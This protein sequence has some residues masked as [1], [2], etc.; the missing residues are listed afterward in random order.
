MRIPTDNF[1]SPAAVTRFFIVC[2]IGL[3]LDL[4]TKSYAFS[5]LADPL[6]HW[7]WP[8]GWPGPPLNCPGGGPEVFPLIFNLADILLRVGVGLMIIY[9]LFTPSAKEDKKPTGEPAAD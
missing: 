1:K 4:F 9:S 8:G 5:H 7:K 3:A 6:P 2:L